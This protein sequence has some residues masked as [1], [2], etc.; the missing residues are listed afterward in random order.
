MITYFS[1]SYMTVYAPFF[2]CEF[3]KYFKEFFLLTFVMSIKDII[4]EEITNKKSSEEVADK[5][6]SFSTS[7]VCTGLKEFIY[8]E[9]HIHD[10]LDILVAVSCRSPK[11][12]EEFF[13]VSNFIC[14]VNSVTCSSLLGPLSSLFQKA[15]EANLSCSEEQFN[16]VFERIVMQCDPQKEVLSQRKRLFTIFEYILTKENILRCSK[17]YLLKLLALFDGER[18]PDLVYSLLVLVNLLCEHAN[19]LVFGEIS[20]SFFELTASYFPIVFSQTQRVTVTKKDLQEVLLKCMT[21]PIFEVHCIP[22]LLLRMNSPSQNVKKEVLNTMNSCLLSYERMSIL[23]YK[24]IVSCVVAE[25]RKISPSGKSATD[26]LSLCCLV[27]ETVSK[28]SGSMPSEEIISLFS[29]LTEDILSSLD[30]FEA[31]QMFSTLISRV[32]MGSWEV[33]V[34]LSPY[35][36]SFVA[37]LTTIEINSCGLT[38]L[39]AVFTSV[40]DIIIASKPYMGV[41]NQKIDRIIEHLLKT[42]ENV[43][44]SLDEGQ[45]D[46]LTVLCTA[47]FL[48]AFLQFNFYLGRHIPPAIRAVILRS[49]LKCNTMSSYASEQIAVLLSKYVALDWDNTQSSIKEFIISSRL[50]LTSQAKDLLSVIG[51]CCSTAAAFV[52]TQ[53]ILNGP[54]GD[55][56]EKREVVERILAHV[57]ELKESDAK[58]ILST[59]RVSGNAK[60]VNSFVYLFSKCK[61]EFCCHQLSLWRNHSLTEVAALLS[62]HQ[63][64]LLKAEDIDSLIQSFLLLAKNQDEGKRFVGLNGLIGCY[65]YSDLNENC[66]EGVSDRNCFICYLWGVSLVKGKSLSRTSG[67]RCFSSIFSD[68]ADAIMN[69]LSFKPVY[70]NGSTGSHNTLLPFI[71]DYVEFIL[72]ICSTDKLVQVLLH[73][74]SLVKPSEIAECSSQLIKLVKEGRIAN[75]KFTVGVLVAVYQSDIKREHMSELIF[76]PKIK[77]ALFDGIKSCSSHDR[78]AI[79]NFLCDAGV[80]FRSCEDIIY[81]ELKKEI[82][83]Q[84]QPALIDPKRI[85]RQAAAKCRHVWFLLH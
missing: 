44:K 33:C 43:S 12:R 58:E 2:F 26:L 39:S 40:T 10:A 31:T 35:L 48:V 28:R 77:N 5:L 34:E 4:T 17:A 67:E 60:D 81:D 46:T 68:S 20:N 27:L 75:K 76:D 52:I 7:E 54:V 30:N 18:N 69:I 85:V 70:Q 13:F 62:G 16:L 6:S 47:E 59:L 21:Q 83:S 45:S 55:S 57:K 72:T 8:D 51:S 11:F 24:E 41:F 50:T 79:F 14:K 38:I 84:T 29:P 9:T 25:A 56:D 80:Y 36:C 53:L 71:L 15:K 1:I 3:L 61:V 32:L 22:F 82:L 49:L 63:K 64:L 66:I 19:K 74:L 37:G 73:V 42:A 23:Q 65:L 78:C